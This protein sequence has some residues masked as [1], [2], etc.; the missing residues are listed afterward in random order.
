MALVAKQFG[1]KD[2]FICNTS[3]IDS[4]RHGRP[5]T[6]M[7]ETGQAGVDKLHNG[8]IVSLVGT[9]ETS[10]KSKPGNIL[11]HV[12]GIAL[13][14][15]PAVSLV[16]KFII[17]EPEINVEQYRRIDNSLA[18]FGD[19]PLQADATH[20]AYELAKYDR[21][22][23]SQAYFKECQEAADENAMEIFTRKLIPG[24]TCNIGTD[25]QLEIIEGTTGTL[26]I[27]S[28]RPQRVPLMFNE[29]HERM[30]E[31]YLMIKLEVK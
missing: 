24:N 2:I 7:F 10:A 12:N 28:V 21:I 14:A 22:E 1:A 6:V 19:K 29:E 5:Q 30:P 3:N 11:D 15:D 17:V 8:A 13:I 9:Q 27:V 25:G 23:Y 4:M 16:G 31:S 26:R 20:T 18:A